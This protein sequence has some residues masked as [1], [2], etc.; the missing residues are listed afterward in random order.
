[1]AATGRFAIAAT[2]VASTTTE[3]DESRRRTSA[4]VPMAYGVGSPP[5]VADS[6]LPR[7]V[8]VMQQL[9]PPGAPCRRV[10]KRDVRELR[11]RR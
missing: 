11:T 5:A 3:S 8:V 2:M 9:R 7:E 4:L 1:M 6:T 10:R